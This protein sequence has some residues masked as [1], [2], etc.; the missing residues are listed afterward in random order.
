MPPTEK[1]T[2]EH[3]YTHSSA[4]T[5]KMEQFVLTKYSGEKSHLFFVLA[6]LLYRKMS[7]GRKRQCKTIQMLDAKISEHSNANCVW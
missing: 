1:I 2:T 5:L 7:F 4:A 6:V 3:E